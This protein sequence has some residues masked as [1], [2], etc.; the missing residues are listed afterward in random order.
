M[1]ILAK[2]FYEQFGKNT[3]ISAVTEFGDRPLIF[4]F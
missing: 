2:K 4:N 1:D 3:E